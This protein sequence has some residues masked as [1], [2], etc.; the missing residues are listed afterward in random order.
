[1]KEELKQVEETK[2]DKKEYNPNSVRI[3]GCKYITHRMLKRDVYSSNRFTKVN[4]R[5]QHHLKRKLDKHKIQ[6]VVKSLRHA[7]RE[8]LKA[9]DIKEV[10]DDFIFMQIRMKEGIRAKAKLGED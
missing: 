7:N 1:M 4:Q 5:T 10:L 8:I 9:N 2:A 3:I 6:K